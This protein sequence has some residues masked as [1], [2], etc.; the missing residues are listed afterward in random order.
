M[1]R[2][3]LGSGSIIDAAN[4]LDKGPSK[5]TK[6]KSARN[7]AFSKDAKKLIENVSALKNIVGKNNKTWE[8]VA[9][10][11]KKD[12]LA[13][14]SAEEDQ[15]YTLNRLYNSTNLSAKERKLTNKA[16][17]KIKHKQNA[18]NTLVNGFYN[19]FT[20]LSKSLYV[21]HRRYDFE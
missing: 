12:H 6:S 21:L 14:R 9:K 15:L 16:I 1:A 8:Q 19:S 10:D 4:N 20:D 3:K 18:L 17:N 13:K 7:E 11:N 5:S 2:T